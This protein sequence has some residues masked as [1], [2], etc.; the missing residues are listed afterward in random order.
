MAKTYDELAAAAPER[1]VVLDA[2]QPPETV[3]AAALKP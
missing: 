1:F 2:T 3:L